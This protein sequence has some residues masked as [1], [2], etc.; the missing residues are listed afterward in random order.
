M[1][2]FYIINN[3]SCQIEIYYTHRLSINTFSYNNLLAFNINIIC[4][5]Y[6]LTASEDNIIWFLFYEMLIKETRNKNGIKVKICGLETDPDYQ[7]W[8]LRH[9]AQCVYCIYQRLSLTYF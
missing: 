8:N 7:I 4:T 9:A 2:K 5:N 1:C 6:Y 3:N